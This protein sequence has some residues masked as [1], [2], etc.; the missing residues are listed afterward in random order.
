MSSDYESDGSDEQRPVRSL[1][2]PHNGHMIATWVSAA[3]L[4]DNDELWED[5]GSVLCT[6]R[7][8]RRSHWHS[9]RHAQYQGAGVGTKHVLDGHHN[10]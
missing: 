8:L 6:W 4:P 7:G 9:A 3:G 1:A 5:P 10:G 2:W